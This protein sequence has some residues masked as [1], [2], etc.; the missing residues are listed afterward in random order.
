MAKRTLVATAV[1]AAAVGVVAAGY[2]LMANR[3]A[4]FCGFCNR[5]IHANAKVIAEVG[6]R[7]RTVCCARCALSEAYQKKKQLRLISVTDYVSSKSLDPKQAYFV[8]GSQKVLCSH[9]EPIFDE[10][11]HPQ[12]VVFDR[13]SPGAYAFARREDAQAF[14]RQ[15]GGVVVR[16][17]EMQQGVN[18]Q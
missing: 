18:A 13:C 9:D 16:L 8:D 15:N 4:T 2:R 12:H 5:S 11:K 6:G 17:T 10:A 1:L 14:A 3:E 7:R